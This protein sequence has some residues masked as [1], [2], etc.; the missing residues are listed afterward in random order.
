MVIALTSALLLL[1]LGSMSGPLG[2]AWGGPP[3]DYLVYQWFFMFLACPA[4]ALAMF[5]SSFRV[6]GLPIVL[7]AT[8]LMGWIS[9]GSCPKWTDCLSAPPVVGISYLPSSHSYS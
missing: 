8:C 3:R 9:L 1:L 6:A 7:A 2:V 5:P 4:H